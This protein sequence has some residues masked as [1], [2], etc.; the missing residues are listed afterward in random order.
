MTSRYSGVIPYPLSSTSMRMRSCC[1]FSASS[2][3]MRNQMLPPSFVYLT[4]LDSRLIRIWFSRVSSPNRCSCRIPVTVTSKLC[5]FAFAA[6]RMMASTE[7]TIFPRENFP[8]VST[9]LPLS[10]LDTSK[11]S[12]IR[13]K[14]C[15]PDTMIFFVYSLTFPA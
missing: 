13:L 6:G 3:I 5:P 8:I 1:S 9:T 10:I 7:A 11:T 4:A 14:R 15:W 12:L 2:P